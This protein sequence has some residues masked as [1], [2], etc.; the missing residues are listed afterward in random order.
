MK[1]ILV[2]TGPTATG[3]TSAAIAMCKKFNGEIVSADSRQVYRGLDI[4]TGK[5]LD[6][7]SKV[8][9]QKSK[10]QIK[11]KK[12]EIKRHSIDGVPVWL[13]DVV[14][15]KVQFNVSDWLDC[16]CRVI[17]DIW[18][19]GKLPIVVGGTG[20][21]IRALTSGIPSLKIAPDKK[22]RKRL[23]PL[24]LSK[25]QKELKD[26]A[27]SVWLKTNS[28]DQSNLRRLVRK[29]EIAT[30]GKT[31]GK[32]DSF[33][34]GTD[35]LSIGLSAP[36]EKIYQKIDKR[37]KKRID[38]GLLDEIKMLLKKGISWTDPGMNTLAYKEFRPYLEGEESL[39]EA[40]E[41]WR[42]DEHHYAKRQQTWFKKE[43]RIN[44][45]DITEDN[46]LQKMTKLVNRWYSKTGANNEPKDKKS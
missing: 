27:P 38:Q 12:F 37:V 39:K 24:S 41:K 20:F 43:K 19:R 2:I 29:I 9:D 3:K 30:A 8:K 34:T 32:S 14:S 5:D 15:P 17:K 35:F 21:Y 45:F 6:E 31:K 25:L 33:L 13:L 18:E 22:L 7:K 36:R 23:N 40:I 46:Y 44:W 10:I 1:K 16:A 28:S 26:I 4:G 42:L 11:N